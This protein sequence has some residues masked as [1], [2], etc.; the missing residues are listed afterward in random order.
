MAEIVSPADREWLLRELRELIAQQPEPF[1]NAP[2]LEPTPR[3][4]PDAFEANEQGIG[5]LLLRILC[6]AGLEK[7]DVQVDTFSQPDEVREIDERGEAKSWGHEGAA[8]WFAGI[9]E[10][11]CHFGVAVERIGDPEMLVA[12]L[13]HEVAHAW[14]HVHG[15]DEADRDLEERLTDL[16]TVHLGF[17]LLTTNAAYRYRS[18]TEERGL[19]SYTRWSHTRSGYLPPEA[20]SYLLAI[21]VKARALGW[22]ERRRLIAKL[23]ANQASFFR[24]AFGKIGSP[25]ELR[26]VLGLDASVPSGLN[27]TGG[28]SGQN[29]HLRTAPPAW[30][31][32]RPR[33]RT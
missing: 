2:I 25:V 14:R 13:C 12:S 33:Q 4:F 21:Q 6:Y 8:A 20:M 22:W 18:G 16:T 9:A 31:S 17:G 23:E 15:L 29:R 7:L 5:V 24:W 11:R 3:W 1:L 32:T 30:P 26:S 19:R 10:G 28:A 27:G